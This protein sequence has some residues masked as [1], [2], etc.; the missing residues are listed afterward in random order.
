MPT[1]IIIS[2]NFERKAKKFV[3]KYASLKSEI[4]ELV[5][6]IRENPTLGIQVFENVYKIRLACK[7]KGV[8]KSRGFR[9][10]SYIKEIDGEEI[11][12]FLTLLSIYDKSE[13]STLSQSE[14]EDII[15]SLD[16]EE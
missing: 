4:R 1:K 9:V 16:D 7:S 14:I 15:D 6:E 12:V 11:E 5:I 2:K 13:T 10:I 8:G 3:K